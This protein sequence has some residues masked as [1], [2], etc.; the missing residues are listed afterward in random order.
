MGA[1]ISRNVFASVY[2][3]NDIEKYIRETYTPLGL[4][5]KGSGDEFVSL[6]IGPK[7]ASLTFFTFDVYFR[8]QG[9][10]VLDTTNPTENNAKLCLPGYYPAH[11]MAPPPSP[12]D[13]QM[14]VVS[15][16]LITSAAHNG[17]SS[18]KTD[19]VATGYTIPRW[20]M[21]A[22]FFFA[23]LAIYISVLRPSFNVVLSHWVPALFPG[24]QGD[25]KPSV[26]LTP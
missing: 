7:F 8:Y 12:T 26:R 13:A 19:D 5:V 22:F 23:L 14:Q 21:Y 16:E 3:I 11:N 1:H 4:I 17:S 9:T 10:L 20:Q 25:T 24:G 15:D 18:T 6:I 2:T